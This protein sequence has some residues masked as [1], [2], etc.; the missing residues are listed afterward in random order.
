MEHQLVYRNKSRG[1]ISS[2][3]HPPALLRKVLLLLDEVDEICPSLTFKALAASVRQ[4]WARTMSATVVTSY[5]VSWRT[6]TMGDGEGDESS[7]IYV[8]DN[9]PGGDEKKGFHRLD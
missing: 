3:N 9:W 1:P 6:V 5:M 2:R 8:L 7:V 4:F